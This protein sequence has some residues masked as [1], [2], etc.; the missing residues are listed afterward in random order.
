MEKER[1]V[2]RSRGKIPLL[3]KKSWIAGEENS[4]NRRW[5][6]FIQDVGS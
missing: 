6:A 2:F 5:K 3:V 1:L 4:G